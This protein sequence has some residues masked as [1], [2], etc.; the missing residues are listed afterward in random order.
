MIS[1]CC[2]KFCIERHVKCLWCFSTGFRHVSKAVGSRG[3]ERMACCLWR[4]QGDWSL[5]VTTLNSLTHKHKNL[6]TV[7][8]LRWKSVNKSK[9]FKYENPCHVIF[10]CFQFLLTG[11]CLE[12][13]WVI[14][15]GFSH[16]RSFQFKSFQS[17]IEHDVWNL[18]HADTSVV[19]AMQT[20]PWK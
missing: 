1:V 10:L 7:I 15:D 11:F 13:I 14:L 20:T 17:D 12:V 3:A 16:W 6:L 4:P 8:P 2:Q 19:C 18:Q 9:L 5:I